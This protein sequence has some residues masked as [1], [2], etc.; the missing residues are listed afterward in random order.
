[1][2]WSY[3][4]AGLQGAFFFALLDTFRRLATALVAVACFNEALTYSKI[5]ALGLAILAIFL[6]SCAA[7][8]R[9]IRHIAGE[10]F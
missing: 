10:S 8:L 5:V 6:H 1:M 9:R 7:T 2:T 4:R 3:N